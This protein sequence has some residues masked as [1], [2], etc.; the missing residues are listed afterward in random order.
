MLCVLRASPTSS[1]QPARQD[2]GRA[3]AAL[4][5]QV[6]AGSLGPGK[7]R[8]TELGRPSASAQ[9]LWPVTHLAPPTAAADSAGAGSSL[10]CLPDCIAS[11][12][13]TAPPEASVGRGRQGCPQ[14]H[15]GGEAANFSLDT[16]K[17]GVAARA[18]CRDQ[19]EMQ[20]PPK[21]YP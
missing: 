3:G 19:S 2:S 8:E 20:L 15:E 7:R 14:R 5:S 11:V 10:P 4:A 9:P 18:G 16:R 17:G 21:L 1:K 6:P 13:M 12:P